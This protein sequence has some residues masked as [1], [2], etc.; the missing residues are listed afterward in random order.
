MEKILNLGDWMLGLGKK[1]P[2]EDL[3]A[4]NIFGK[5]VIEAKDCTTNDRRYLKPF[6][7]IKK[8]LLDWPLRYQLINGN[9][10][11]FLLALMMGV[12]VIL[13]NI[14]PLPPAKIQFPAW[15]P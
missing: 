14:S 12:H 11:L 7:S 3:P 15:D 8:N 6:L 5:T 13:T 1:K 10:P 2:S 9:L 4:L